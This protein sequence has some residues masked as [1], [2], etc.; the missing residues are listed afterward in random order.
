MLSGLERDASVSI[1]SADQ[2]TREL[3]T[4]RG[5]G[6]L[7]RKGEEV[8]VFE[9]PNAEV[10][11]QV[12]NRVE[13]SFERTLRDDWARDLHEPLVLLSE[14]TRA[15]AV[16]VEGRDGI[17]YLDKFIVTPDAQGEGLGA[18]MW[19]VL[20]ARY[21]QV[22]W[23]ARAANPVAGWYF[24]QADSSYRQDGW[25]VF[26]IGIRDAVQRER[27]IQDAMERDSG[28]TEVQE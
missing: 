16:V 10:L 9:E 28:W 22:Y 7:V 27:V 12:A 3:F 1:T 21:S 6:T 8:R 19:Q 17:A 18:A 25:V 15:A 4:Y 26:T 5:A 2:L 14:S 11:G 23:R 24:Q 20:R 13:S